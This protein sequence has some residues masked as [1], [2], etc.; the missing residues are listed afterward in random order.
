MKTKIEVSYNYSKLDN[1]HEF[2]VG[3]IEQNEKSFW[4]YFGI[5]I[6]KSKLL[7][8]V[9]NGTVGGIQI[10]PYQ[11]E[12]SAKNYISVFNHD[13]EKAG[14]DFAKFVEKMYKLNGC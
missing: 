12:T 4:F 9:N 2:G 8:I 5:E 1:C 11:I 6:G 10:F 3:E 13:T 7:P 14:K